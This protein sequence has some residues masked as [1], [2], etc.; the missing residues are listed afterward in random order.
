MMPDRE[1]RLRHRIDQLID[2]RD[3]ALELAERR[4]KK[5]NHYRDLHRKQAN[6]RERY[7]ALPVD[8]KCGRVR[9]KRRELAA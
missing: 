3:K 2:E 1:Y 4:L 9:P 6:W 7:Y 5:L 8:C